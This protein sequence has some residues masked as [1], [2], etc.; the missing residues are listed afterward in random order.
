[1]IFL[2]ISYTYLAFD[3]PLPSL[4]LQN[5]RERNAFIVTQAPMEN[6]TGDFWRMIWETKSAAIV[7]L[8]ELVEG[9]KVSEE[10]C[11]EEGVT[12]V[13][14][15]QEMCVKY[16]PSG[17]SDPGVFGGYQVELSEDEKDRGSYITRRFKLS[18]LDKVKG[19]HNKKHY[20]ME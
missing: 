15:F 19:C 20:D 13:F 4:S 10:P 16:W 18:P 8:T 6:T 14:L 12:V 3:Y 5:Y 7:M 2:V 17:V 1:M 11:R 9:D